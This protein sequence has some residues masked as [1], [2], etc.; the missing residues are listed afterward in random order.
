MRLFGRNDYGTM[1]FAVSAFKTEERGEIRGLINEFK[2]YIKLE[3]VLVF[4]VP[5]VSFEF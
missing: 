1:L 3:E 4:C 5:C 2:F